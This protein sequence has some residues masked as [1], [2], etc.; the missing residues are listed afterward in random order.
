MNYASTSGAQKEQQI[1]S[2]ASTGKEIK[3]KSINT[4]N[5]QKNNKK[6]FN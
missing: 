4:Q 5:W 1:D 3:D 2:K 6:K